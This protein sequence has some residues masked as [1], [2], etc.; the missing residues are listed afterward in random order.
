MKI[1]F[2]GNK[3]YLQWPLPRNSPLQIDL[4]NHYSD[5]IVPKLIAYGRFYKIMKTTKQQEKENYY[6]EELNFYSFKPGN[7]EIVYTSFPGHITYVLN[8]ISNKAISRARKIIIAVPPLQNRLHLAYN[9]PS[10]CRKILELIFFSLYC[11]M[12]NCELPARSA[13]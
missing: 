11:L 4:G 6:Q 13:L 1:A 5:V 12:G 9:K 3:S 8:L 2:L 7:D 10:Y